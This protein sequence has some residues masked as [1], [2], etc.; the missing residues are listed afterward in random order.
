MAVVNGVPIPQERLDYVVK[1][2]VQQGQK[3]D[4]TLRKNVKDAL[5][6]R[7]VIAQEA[8]RRVWTRTRGSRPRWTWPS[9]SS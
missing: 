9:R 6:M 4:E 1:T 2:Q 7:E 8:S 3:D 5:I